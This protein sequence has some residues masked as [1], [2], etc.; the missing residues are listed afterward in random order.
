VP[1]PAK[2]VEFLKTLR[3][4]SGIPKV[5]AFSKACGKANPNMVNYLAGKPVP[6]KKFLRSCTETLFGWGVVPI[7]E[8]ESIPDNLNSL[9]TDPG[10]YIIYDSG[11]QVLYVGKATSLRGEVRQ[12][13]SRNIPVGLRFGPSLKKKQPKI[14]DLA[15]HL[16]LY[17]IPSA[18][19]RHNIEVLLLRGF[20]N[21]THNSNI[22]NF[23]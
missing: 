15:T 7:M 11:A 9:P 8:V 4:L 5:S 16:S 20:A 6:G 12:T 14:R 1:R 19:L 22:G 3:D 2:N 10:V 13:L 18:Q 17:A 21:Q 23:K